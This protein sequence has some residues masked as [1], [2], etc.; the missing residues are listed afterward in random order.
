MSLM[1]TQDNTVAELRDASA[2][3]LQR[4]AELE[5]QLA[6]ELD[7][8]IESPIGSASVRPTFSTDSKHLAV[9]AADGSVHIWDANSGAPVSV[10]TGHEGPVTDVCYSPDGSRTHRSEEQPLESG[11]RQRTNQSRYCTTE[12]RMLHNR[13]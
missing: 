2:E 9:G 7:V 12:I 13:L 4:M 1:A 6:R 8:K 3:L 11:T 10:M 5:W